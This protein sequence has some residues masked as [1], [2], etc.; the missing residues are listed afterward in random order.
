MK[1]K[2]SLKKCSLSA[3]F[4][5]LVQKQPPIQCIFTKWDLPTQ[6]HHPTIMV[7]IPVSVNFLNSQGIWI[8]EESYFRKSLY[9]YSGSPAV[10]LALAVSEG[11]AKWSSAKCQIMGTF[12]VDC[13]KRLSSILT[14][15]NKRIFS[16]ADVIVLFKYVFMD[17]TTI[18]CDIIYSIIKTDPPKLL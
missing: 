11:R 16:V 5:H 1:K 14:I 7:S 4:D 8:F 9:L 17:L 15:C 18:L 10:R 6:T 12:A 13:I 3:S 2:K